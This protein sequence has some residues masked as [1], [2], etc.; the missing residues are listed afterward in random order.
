[1]RAGLEAQLAQSLRLF[2]S[3]Q[4]WLG[5][6]RTHV[7]WGAVCHD[8]GDLD[9]ARAHWEQAAA[10]WERSGLTDELAR[11]RALI[12]RLALES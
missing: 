9:A 4:C 8:R 3:G 11:T 12:E 2:E 5:A 6:A 7:A 1:M 10:Q